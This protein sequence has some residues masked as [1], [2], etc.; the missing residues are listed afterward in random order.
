MIPSI[1]Y[2]DLTS[3]GKYFEC[4]IISFD[5][6]ILVSK[7]KSFRSQEI[8]LAPRRSSEI[9][10]LKS[11]FYSK[12]DAAGYDASSVYYNLYPPIVNINLNGSDFSG[13]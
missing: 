5:L 13:H 6:D 2:S 10:L 12:R 9:V 7:K 11:T 4:I 8:N 1:Q 3:G